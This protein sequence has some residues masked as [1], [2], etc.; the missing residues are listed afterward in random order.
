[1]PLAVVASLAFAAALSCV[2]APQAGARTYADVGAKHWAKSYI[3]WVTEQRIG[4]RR[5]LDDFSGA[6]FKPGQSLTRAQ[7]AR[8]LVLAA[9]RQDDEV[10]PLALI[11]VPTDHP[12]YREI[13][14]AVRLQLLG[15]FGKEF[16]PEAPVLVWQADRAAVM[17]AKLL[18]PTQDW[19]M[20]RSLNPSVWRPNP[21]W[22]TG[23]PSYFATE[24]AARALG[25]RFN[26]PYG[27]E[28]LELF[29]T[30]PIRRDEVAYTLYQALRLSSWQVYSLRRFNSVT[31]PPLSDRQREILSFA[32]KYVGYPFV[33]AGEYPS[34]KSPYGYQ[35]HGGFD[36]SGFT[37]WVMKITFKY[38]IP[39]TQRSAAQ[40]AA[41]AKPRITRAKLQPCDLIFFGPKGPKS[42]AGSVYHAGL[43]I[44]NGWFFHSTGSTDGVSLASLDWQGW[45]WNSDFAWG[46]RLLKAGELAPPP[47]PSPTP[48]VTPTAAGTPTPSPVP[49]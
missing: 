29:P 27:S 2:W 47:S 5:L 22:S 40:M 23:A 19:S 48:V 32:F 21:D 6:R 20:L 34:Q 13:Q 33:Y 49:S 38:P 11:D 3:D 30:E 7:L 10:K 42:A 36:C 9:R 26:H 16:R 12:Y 35:E 28:K 44:G 8:A 1:M 41:A 4:E 25:F 43:Y 15:T 37:W 46:R 17:L 18:H 39:V 14:I 45:G 24:V 31:L